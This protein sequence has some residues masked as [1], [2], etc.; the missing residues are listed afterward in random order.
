[1]ADATL[2]TGGPVFWDLDGTLIH[3]EAV[4][5]AS[6]LHAC[7]RHGRHFATL[8]PIPPGSS[9]PGVYRALFDVP[10]GAPLPAGYAHW[11]ASTIEY[12][13]AHLHGAQPAAPAVRLCRRL[14]ELGV[15]QT[16]VSNS[17]PRIIEAALEHLALRRHFTHVCSGDEVARGKPHPDVYLRAAALHGHAPAG[18]I[19]I[20]DS[21]NG[22]AAARAA[23][24]Q[25]V[26]ASRDPAVRRDA[27]HAID[28]DDAQAWH[29][30]AQHWNGRER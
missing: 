4:H 30:L 20:E 25:V 1:M 24:V 7:R 12:V 11:Y 5:D 26:A 19:A 13:V 14:A 10:A 3:S 9:G 2:V 17:S 16:L 22:V 21:G 6:I 15:P 23:G 29:G 28:P 27:H 18:C 8:P